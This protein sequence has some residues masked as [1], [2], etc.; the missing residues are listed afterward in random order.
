[1]ARTRRLLL[2]AA[3]ALVAGLGAASPAPAATDGTS[4]TLMF[5]E[6][7]RSYG[8]SFTAIEFKN[9]GLVGNPQPLGGSERA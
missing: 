5:G 6:S 2:S 8:L 9:N 1:M 7:V 4:N 3:V